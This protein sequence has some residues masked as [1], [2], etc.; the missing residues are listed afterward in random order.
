MH[1]Q[2]HMYLTEL[3]L[4]PI[5][6]L[7]ANQMHQHKIHWSTW[8][9]E[10]KPQNKFSVF[11]LAS[12]R[13]SRDYDGL[14]HLEHFHVTECFISLKRIIHKTWEKWAFRRIASTKLSYNE[15]VTFSG[16]KSTSLQLSAL[17]LIK[18]CFSLIYVI[19]AHPPTPTCKSLKS[20]KTKTYPTICRTK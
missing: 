18:V 4:K 13:F 3:Y 6:N 2:A 16:I 5:Y 14:T 9:Q 10:H 19:A 7:Y 20:L 11:C 1:I 17:Q 15:N 12:S 8:V